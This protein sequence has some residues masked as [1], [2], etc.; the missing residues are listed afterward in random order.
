MT[1]M[2]TIIKRKNSVP[3]DAIFQVIALCEFLRASVM[4]PRAHAEST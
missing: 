4:S 1:I 2:I 3:K